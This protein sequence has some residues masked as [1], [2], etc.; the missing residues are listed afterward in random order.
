[1]IKVISTYGPAV[2]EDSMLERFCAESDVI[3]I[4]ISHQTPS[5]AEKLFNKLR[6]FK[7]P[8]M[9][10]TSGPEIRIRTSAKIEIRKGET[11]KIGMDESSMAYFDQRIW[12]MLKP[13][14]KIYLNDGQSALELVSKS[15]DEMIF[16]SLDDVVI[17]DRAGVNVKGRP[18]KFPS[19]RDSDITVLEN[20][21]PEFVALSY[22]R[23]AAD[24]KTARKHTDADI[25][26]KIENYEGVKNIES[27]LEVADGVMVARGD[28]GI[29]VPEEKVPLIQKNII[30]LANSY[31]KPSIVATQV[32]YSMVSNP[33]PT[34]AEVSDVANAVLDGADAILLSNETAVGKYPLNSIRVI[35]RVADSVAPYVYSKLHDCS[36]AKCIDPISDILSRTIYTIAS[37]KEIT[38]IVV[39]TRSGYAVRLISR[40]KLPKS[41]IAITDDHIVA[42]KLN[43]FYNVIPV[44]WHAK[45]KQNLVQR[46]TLLCL[47]NGLL[48][49][50]DTIIF[51]AA[52]R[53]K[54]PGWTNMIEV[55][56]VKDML[57]FFNF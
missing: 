50:D 18:I 19:L 3:R 15:K 56:N 37:K 47:E 36:S 29:E 31:A 27:I 57:E 40:F 53:T 8:I 10:D 21:D 7:K 41:I 55:H 32:L 20:T 42:Q 14:D 25:I 28:L 11:V 45:P 6:K 2:S 12:G 24:V 13:R 44:F 51:T 26:A 46:A 48:K 38:K 9:I 16:K 23:T 35:R 4:N 49:D 17:K 54:R 39:I 30:T 22:T 33:S 43:L 1:M 34:R 52:V 5:E